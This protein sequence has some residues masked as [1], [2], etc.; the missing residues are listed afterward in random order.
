MPFSGDLFLKTEG[1]TLGRP[2]T[3]IKMTNEWQNGTFACCNDVGACFF[4][5]CC[6]CIVAGKNAEAMGENCMVY[7]A[8]SIIGCIGVYTMSTIRGK[9][10]ERYGIQVQQFILS[11]SVHYIGNN[12]FILKIS[13]IA[14]TAEEW[15]RFWTLDGVVLRQR[16]GN[17]ERFPIDEASKMLPS[18]LFIY[19][20]K[21]FI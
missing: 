12:M 13:N 11:L 21:R 3:E 5:C 14:Q 6:P 1:E 20:L 17:R 10:R 19:I 2:R 4:S 7:G 18:F 9:A 8:L 15:K 16:L